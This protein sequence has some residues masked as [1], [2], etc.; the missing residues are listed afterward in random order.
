MRCVSNKNKITR[1]VDHKQKTVLVIDYSEVHQDNNRFLDSIP[2][3]RMS[4]INVTHSE[5][6]YNLNSFN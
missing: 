5:I 2:I 6:K 1:V 3:H 4:F